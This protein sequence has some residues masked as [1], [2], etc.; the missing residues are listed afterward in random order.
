MEDAIQ[1]VFEN[2]CLILLNSILL[3]NKKENLIEITKNNKFNFSP[4]LQFDDKLFDIQF[5]KDLSEL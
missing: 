4:S 2:G 3:L 1:K 5:W